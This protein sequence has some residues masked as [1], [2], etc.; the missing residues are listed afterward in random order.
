MVPYVLDKVKYLILTGAT[1]EKIRDTI[2][3]S[4]GYDP[5]NLPIEINSSWEESIHHAKTIA[6]PGDIVSLSPACAAFDCFAN[7]EKRGEYYK[8]LVLQF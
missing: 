3:S 2:V 6:R 1:A 5:N 4:P 7:F 8:N